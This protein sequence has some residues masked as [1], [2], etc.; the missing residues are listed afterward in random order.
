MTPTAAGPNRPR[1]L[2][3][4]IHDVSPRHVHQVE[5]LHGHLRRDGDA[6]LALLVVPD[7]WEQA[8]IVAGT[9][10]ARRLH[11]WAAEGNELFLHGYT[12][13]D[14]AVHASPAVRF[15]ARHM[16]AGEGEFLGLNRAEAMAR[17]VKGRKLLE[18]ITG[19]PIAGFVAPAWLY[20]AEAKVAL[21]D[22]GVALAEDHWRVWEPVAGRV[23][24]TSPVITWA[25]RTPGRMASS[26]LV[27]AIARHAPLPRVMRIG[28]HPNDC[29]EAAVMR[30][31]ASTVRHVRRS[32]RPSRYGS[33]AGDLACG[34]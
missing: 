9:P 3:L 14:A 31:I 30:S 15:K 5:T 20:G 6:P 22:A 11:R 13:S 21:S 12:H 27:A 4:S 19:S 32:H 17:I 7:F 1:R 25:T 8:P 18:D 10:F 16:T 29:N 26:L 33:L 2:L 28:V 24:A 34:S 23:L